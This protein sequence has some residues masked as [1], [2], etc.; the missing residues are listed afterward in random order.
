M[1]TKIENWLGLIHKTC[2]LQGTKKIYSFLSFDNLKAEHFLYY[3]Q[4]NYAFLNF[5]LLI[6]R[7]LNFPKISA[8]FFI[9]P[10]FI[11]GDCV[12]KK[13]TN[14]F[15]WW[16]YITKLI[17]VGAPHCCKKLKCLRLTWGIFAW[18]YVTTLFDQ[19]GLHCNAMLWEGRNLYMGKFVYRSVGLF[20]YNFF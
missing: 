11:I 1:I 13:V 10:F 17:S 19:C 14:F 16:Q 2:E 15:Y 8:P 7:S 3:L 20:V 9:G 18:I 4:A 6:V 12:R 5:D